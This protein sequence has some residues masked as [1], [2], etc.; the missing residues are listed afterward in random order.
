MQLAKVDEAL[1]GLRPVAMDVLHLLGYV[2][3]NMAGIRKILKKY[4]KNVATNKPQPGAPGL[5]LFW[6]TRTQCALWLACFG[7]GMPMLQATLHPSPSS[8]PF[9]HAV[10]Q[11][12]AERASPCLQGT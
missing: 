1:K 11:Y 9:M 4:A 2:S 7:T 12:D 8:G 3:L 5:C 10:H 6:P